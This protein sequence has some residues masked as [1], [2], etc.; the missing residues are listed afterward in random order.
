M[1]VLQGWDWLKPDK[2][3]WVTKVTAVSC[4]VTDSQKRI[5]YHPFWDQEKALM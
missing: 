3:R 4:P 1:G 2:K 5:G